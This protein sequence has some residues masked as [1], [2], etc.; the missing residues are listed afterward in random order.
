MAEFCQIFD[1]SCTGY[2]QADHFSYKKIVTAKEIVKDGVNRFLIKPN[3]Y[4]GFAKCINRIH[5]KSYLY[6][7]LSK[8]CIQTVSENFNSELYVD[9]IIKEI[10]EII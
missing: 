5:Q 4:D 1:C 6:E 7:Q 8:N 3:D 9:K 10:D 2:K